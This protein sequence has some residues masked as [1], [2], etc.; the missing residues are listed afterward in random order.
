MESVLVEI[1]KELPGQVTIVK[2][3]QDQRKLFKSFEVS[4]LPAVVVIRN[5]EVKKSYLGMVPKEILIQDI[6]EF[7]PS[8][9]KKAEQSPRE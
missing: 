5:A 7:G 9:A 3:T 4:A 1:G 2:V 8:D 6:R